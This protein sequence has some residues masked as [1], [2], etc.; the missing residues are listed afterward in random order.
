MDRREQQRQVM[1]R[2]KR[3]KRRNQI[4]RRSALLVL[5]V[6][7]VILSIKGIVSGGKIQVTEEVAAVEENMGMNPVM[8]CY[9]REKTDG[10]EK[11]APEEPCVVLDAGHGGKDPGT[12]W[13]HVYEKD[14]NLAIVKKLEQ[15]LMEAGCQVILTRCEDVKIGLEERVQIAKD[16]GADIFVSIHQNALENDNVTSGIEIYCSQQSNERSGKLADAIHTYLLDRTGA[17]D[18]GVQ[19]NSDFYVVDNTT[20]PACL[21]ET[22]FITS[23]EERECLLDEAYQEKVARGIA[24]G[25]LEF[26]GI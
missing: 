2:R 18:K 17:K 5:M 3:I 10:E 16:N 21:I 8:V 6:A 11:N 12:L 26:L 20:M 1:R 4:I 25:I 23:K 9:E 15:I 19:K 22:G 13:E 7:A 14:I 24:D